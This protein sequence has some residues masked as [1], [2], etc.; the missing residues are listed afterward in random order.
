MDRFKWLLAPLRAARQ[1]PRPVLL[2]TAASLAAV[3]GAFGIALAVVE[4]RDE[5]ADLTAVE[6]QIGEIDTS[7]GE[8]GSRLDQIEERLNKLTLAPSPAPTPAPRFTPTPLPTTTPEIGSSRDNPVPRG[9]PLVLG[10]WEVTVTD[11]AE[12]VDPNLGHTARVQ[13]R[14]RNIAAGNPASFRFASFVL[15]GSS[16]ELHFSYIPEAA[17]E[18]FILQGDV[19]EGVVHFPQLPQSETGSLLLLDGR[20]FALD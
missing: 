9:E 15:V 3:G 19:V 5:T 2:A 12:G 1:I 11:Y 16:G 20:F 4:W 13:V 14:L 6:E 8:L 7:V 10:A 17:L 18:D